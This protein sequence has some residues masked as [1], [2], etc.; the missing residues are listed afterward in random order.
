MRLST[1]IRMTL[2]GILIAAGVILYPRTEAAGPGA[3]AVNGVVPSPVT[4]TPL[5]AQRS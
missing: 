2:L 5:P 4:V 3:S 1:I